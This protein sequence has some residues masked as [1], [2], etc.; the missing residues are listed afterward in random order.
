MQDATL[1]QKIKPIDQ[2]DYTYWQALYLAFFSPR[3]YIDVIKR[4]RGF[5]FLYF[6]LLILIISIPWG[7]HYT[8]VFLQYMDE[9]II[10]P[11]KQMPLLVIQN[12]QASIDKPQPYFVKSKTQQPAIEINTTIDKQQFS[13]DKSSVFLLITKNGFY[14]RAP[15]INLSALPIDNQLKSERILSKDSFQ[16]NQNEVFDGAEW[17]KQ[18]GIQSMRTKGIFLIFPLILG[19]FWGLYFV[20]GIM[21]ASMGRIISTVILKYKIGYIDS[22]RLTWVASTA[23]IFVINLL[24]FLG[25]RLSGAGLYY[26]ILVAVYFSIAILCVKRE[27]QFLVRQ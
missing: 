3:L 5:G 13:A 9:E 1:N 8:R 10:Y 18:S 24:T 20:V 14:F 12:G 2:P 27:S 26:F 15:S 21:L 22:F 16:K 23:P 19:V 11:F 7:I 4:W 25:V 6:S 17:V